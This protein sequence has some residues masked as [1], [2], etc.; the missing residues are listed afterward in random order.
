MDNL[1]EMQFVE[2]DC[3]DFSG[4]HFNDRKARD[5]AAFVRNLCALREFAARIHTARTA[6]RAVYVHCAEGKN[7]GP[8]SVIAYLM[9][10]VPSVQSLEEAFLWVRRI[11]HRART[12]SNTFHKELKMLCLQQG[13]AIKLHCKPANG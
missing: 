10:Y 6:S 11:R 1:T 3:R 4:G 13:K 9:I 7:R 5:K 8:A 2:V 12:E